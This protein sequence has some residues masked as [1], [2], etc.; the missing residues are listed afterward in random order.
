VLM[1]VYPPSIMIDISVPVHLETVNISKKQNSSTAP[2]T[3]WVIG[4]ELIILC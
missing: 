1:L 4:L 3:G 2:V